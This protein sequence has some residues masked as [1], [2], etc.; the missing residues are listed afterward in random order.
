ME[1][2]KSVEETTPVLKDPFK[3]R[4]VNSVPLPYTRPASNELI[5]PHKLNGD[6]DWQFIKN[7]YLKAGVLTKK[8]FQ[9]ILNE[10]SEIFKK[11]PNCNRVA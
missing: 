2:S 3:D 11:E 7:F 5:F 4:K 1:K 10:A 6:P 9:K 8:Q